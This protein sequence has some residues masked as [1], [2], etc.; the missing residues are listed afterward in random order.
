[1]EFRIRLLPEAAE[2]VEKLYWRAV[3]ASPLRG[4]EWYNGLIAA[5]YSLNNNPRRCPIVSDPALS[6]RQVRHLLYGNKPHV[7]RIVFRVLDE[8][9]TVEILHIRHGAMQR[10]V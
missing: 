10:S 4:Q 9:Q 1:M 6:E 5:L 7:Y 2:D 3:E 8:H